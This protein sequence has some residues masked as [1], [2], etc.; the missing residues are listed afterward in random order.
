VLGSDFKEGNYLL[1]HWD[2]SSTPVSEIGSIILPG[3]PQM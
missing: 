2:I 3:K 1:E